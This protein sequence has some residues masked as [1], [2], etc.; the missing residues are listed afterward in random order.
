MNWITP[1]FE[2]TGSEEGNIELLVTETRKVPAFRFYV[3]CYCFWYANG[4]L[5]SVTSVF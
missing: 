5:Y 3:K 2:V 4:A 1:E